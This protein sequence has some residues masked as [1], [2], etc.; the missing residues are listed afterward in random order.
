MKYAVIKCEDE[1]FLISRVNE[2]L[3]NGWKLYG[4]TKICVD[5]VNIHY[6]QALIKEGENHEK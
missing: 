4:D 2:L 1:D 3:K 6:L 5:E